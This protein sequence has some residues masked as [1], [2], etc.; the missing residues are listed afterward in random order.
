MYTPPKK[1][2][3]SATLKKTHFNFNAGRKQSFIYKL[4][5]LHLVLVT[6]LPCA[7]SS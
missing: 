3:L 4:D 7:R 5:A 6:I 2:L 1:R